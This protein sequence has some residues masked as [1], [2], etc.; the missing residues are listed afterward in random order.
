MSLNG[1]QVVVKKVILIVIYWPSITT[2]THVLDIG[3]KLPVVLS[4]QTA[5]V[6]NLKKIVN[7]HHLHAQICSQK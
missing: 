7:L 3:K 2:L 1:N 5:S 4:K 6:D